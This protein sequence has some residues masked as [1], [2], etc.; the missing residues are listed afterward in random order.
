M[1][2]QVKSNQGSG[3]MGVCGVHVGGIGAGAYGL[4]RATG[5]GKTVADRLA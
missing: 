5:H 1:T 4:N 3:V 2:R